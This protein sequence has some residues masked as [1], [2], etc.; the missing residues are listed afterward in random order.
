MAPPWQPHPA[1]PPRMLLEARPPMSVEPAALVQ[2]TQ[3]ASS[4]SDFKRGAFGTSRLLVISTTSSCSSSPCTCRRL[5]E[6]APRQIQERSTLAHL[7]LYGLHQDR[8][9]VFQSLACATVFGNA[10]RSTDDVDVRLEP[11]RPKA[12]S[13]GSHP[14]QLGSPAVAPRK[15]S[16]CNCSRMTKA[17][18]ATVRWSPLPS[19]RLPRFSCVCVWGTQTTTGT[20]LQPEIVSMSLMHVAGASGPSYLP[21]ATKLWYDGGSQSWPLWCT[22]R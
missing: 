15:C 2:I 8:F 21:D 19:P 12:R 9:H 11:S 1:Q 18:A 10:A 14:E 16:D 5:S 13:Q 7:F 20:Q 3:T 4:L 22:C 17:D 6:Q